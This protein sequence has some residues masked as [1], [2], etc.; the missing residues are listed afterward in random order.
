MSII[1][2]IWY[3]IQW[4]IGFNLIL[5]IVLFIVFKVFIR[6][7]QADFN[8]N[9]Q[10]ADYAIIITAY[11]ETNNL[12]AVVKSIEKLDYSNYLAYIVADNCEDVSHLEFSND[13]I[14]L[15]KPEHVIASNTGSHQYAVAHFV[16][17]HERLT[18]IDSDNLVHPQYLNEMN[19][20]F[21]EGYEAVQGIREA[22]NLDTTF[23]CLDAAR[24]LYYH[25]F[26]GKVLFQLGSSATLAGSGMAFTTCLYSDFLTKHQ[27]QGAGFDKV[28]QY[29]ILSNRKRI[30]FNEK[31]IVYDEK[32]SKSDQLVK[33]RARW[34]NTWFKYFKL[35]FS[36]ITKGL[37]HF[38][39]NQ[40]LFGI[41]L[42]R[43]PLFLFLILSAILLIIN[44]FINP[45]VALIWFAG[46]I[47]FTIGFFIALHHSNTNKK[48]YH[49]L[50]NI[51]HFMALQFI[52]LL[53]SYR[54]NKYSVS[55][56]HF[57]TDGLDTDKNGDH[58]NRT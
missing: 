57:H 58:E 35:G 6:K 5:P 38:N 44:I 10:E 52:S 27:V 37:V 49:S 34:I 26:D 50:L 55:T 24:D 51:P 56:Q 3:L 1:D 53:K 23:S 21:S 47:L 36:L 40:F 32:T 4:A 8:A 39:I 45:I 15:L 2:F 12:F 7:R 9:L 48:I 14:I 41:I 29:F 42:L 33:Q 18:I 20:S 11:Q 46:L 30:A 31:A 25:F 13:K 17:Q 43:P 54:A 19:K 28:L 16:R 22:K